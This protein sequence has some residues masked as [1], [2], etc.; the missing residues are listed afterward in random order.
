MPLR[1]A[2]VRRGECCGNRP[3]GSCGKKRAL[4]T[5]TVRFQE[6]TVVAQKNRAAVSPRTT[7]V[8]R[9]MS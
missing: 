1:R 6:G 7:G 2:P 8:Q 4:R 9:A 5:V 3:C